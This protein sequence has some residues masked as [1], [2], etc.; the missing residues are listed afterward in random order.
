[1]TAAA[2]SLVA[3]A[4]VV[5]VTGRSPGLLTPAA[6]TLAL[7]AGVVLAGSLATAWAPGV[8]WVLWALVL[9][10]L[11]SLL[12]QPRQVDAGAPVAGAALFLMAELAYWSIELR[13]PAR[14]AR[15][16]PARRL[17][18][19]LGVVLAAEALSAVALLTAAPGADAGVVLDAA[20]VAAAVAAIAL[21]LALLGRAR[22]RPGP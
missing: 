19:I 14:Q 22:G 8:G 1:V 7:L 11:L 10:Y 20:G 17:V 4:V 5:A 9:G 16:L 18:T 6:V 13:P 2:G 21:V 15:Q 12:A 3:W